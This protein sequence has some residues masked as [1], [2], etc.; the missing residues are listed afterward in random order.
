MVSR[1]AAEP[2]RARRGGTHLFCPPRSP[3]LR[4][5]KAY[6]ARL[7]PKGN[8]A[9]AT[10]QGARVRTKEGAGLV[11]LLRLQN[12]NFALSVFFIAALIKPPGLGLPVLSLASSGNVPTFPAWSFPGFPGLPLR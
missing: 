1:G 8:V 7:L 3:R 12:P 11:A 10:L 9:A 6:H 4:V 2:R 5:R